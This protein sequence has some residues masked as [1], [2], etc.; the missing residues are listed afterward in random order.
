[1]KHNQTTSRILRRIGLIKEDNTTNSISS[2]SKT[3]TTSSSTTTTTAGPILGKEKGE[4]GD[5][6]MYGSASYE[7]GTNPY[8]YSNYQYDDEDTQKKRRRKKKGKKKK[9]KKKKKHDEDDDCIVV[10]GRVGIDNGI[11]NELWYFR[12]DIQ[13]NQHHW[14][15][16]L[17]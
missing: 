12:E 1:M 8:L 13:A 3:I 7:K 14:W 4:S 6:A 16:K 2:T 15:S 9:R 11:E 5:L 10:D 17:T